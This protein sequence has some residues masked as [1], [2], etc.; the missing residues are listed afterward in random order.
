MSDIYGISVMVEVRERITNKVLFEDLV[1]LVFPR[2]ERYIT[3]F[4]KCGKDSLF[5]VDVD[6]RTR[7]AGIISS[8]QTHEQQKIGS[9]LIQSITDRKWFVDSTVVEVID[10]S[11]ISGLE[12]WY[13]E[14]SNS[15][16]D[17]FLN[18]ENFGE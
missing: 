4:S 17:Q 3:M 18:P 10:F 15:K 7:I 11:S 6:V 13:R 8:N 5:I 9:K 1:H 14:N 2:G 12:K 16:F